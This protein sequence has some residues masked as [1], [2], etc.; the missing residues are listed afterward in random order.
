VDRLPPARLLFGALTLGALSLVVYSLATSTPPPVWSLA[1]LPLYVVYCTLGVLVPQLEMYGDVA[2]RGPSD[3]PRVALTFD[4]GPNPETTRRILGL[5]SVTRHR[6]T[7]FMVGQKVEQ[8]PDVVR[9]VL[10]AGHGIGLHGY[11]HDRLYSFRAPR[12][13]E[14]D[15]ERASHAVER[16]AGVAP[17]LFRPP[18]GYVSH[19]TSSGARRAGV[20]LVA[21]SARGIDGLGATDPARVAR[22]IEKKLRPGAIVM[23]HDA[24]ERDDFVPASL[25]ALPLVLAALDAK[26]L[27]G[28]PVH[29]L[30]GI[31]SERAP[32]GGRGAQASAVRPTT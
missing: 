20:T 17:S 4:D 15:I 32:H 1:L 5:L 9:E 12:W 24:A 22:R 30:L 3:A 8:H 26:G 25:E 14:R 21:W 29:A 2:W 31:S 11:L 6:A 28:V 7:F 13:V 18:V 27:T 16:A 19:R 23:L 10:A